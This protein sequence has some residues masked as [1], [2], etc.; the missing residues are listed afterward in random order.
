MKGLY[1]ITT[2]E[3]KHVAECTLLTSAHS[4]KN[5]TIYLSCPHAFVC[6]QKNISR[7]HSVFLG[8]SIER[9]RERERRLESRLAASEDAR[10]KI[11]AEA[12]R[13]QA[14]LDEMRG[15]LGVPFAQVWHG[16][17]GAAE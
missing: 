3:H 7:K 13:L 5:R 4:M 16:E 6:L 15:R 11:E 1:D 17:R 8:S 10:I 2:A 14:F 12:E 9:Q